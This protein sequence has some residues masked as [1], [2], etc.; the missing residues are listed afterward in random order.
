[1]QAGFERSVN[2]S[3][4]DAV[5]VE[6]DKDPYR[7]I[8]AFVEKSSA[9]DSDFPKDG[10]HIFFFFG[11]RSIGDLKDHEVKISK[12]NQ[13]G[14]T[15]YKEKRSA[16]YW[17]NQPPLRLLADIFWCSNTKLSYNNFIDRSIFGQPLV[18]VI[19]AQAGIYPSA[20]GTTHLIS[21]KSIFNTQNCKSKI[22][23]FLKGSFLFCLLM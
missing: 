9:G 15:E 23:N 17:H 19:P 18:F 16:K 12:L 13:Q 20:D 21:Q 7:Q 4:T 1:M 11:F 8:G 5:E 6:A 10:I 14:K 2:I 22:K 3:K